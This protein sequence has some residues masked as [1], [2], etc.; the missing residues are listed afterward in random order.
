MQQYR[1]AGGRRACVC[2]NYPRG[3][4]IHQWAQRTRGGMGGPGRGHVTAGLLPPG[5]TTCGLTAP[6][7][8]RHELP[9]WLVFR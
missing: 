4:S 1:A 6:D 7:R 3:L 5:R 2:C 9:H 8:L